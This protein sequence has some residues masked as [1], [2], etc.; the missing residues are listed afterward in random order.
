M[1]KYNQ[2]RDY[3][4]FTLRTTDEPKSISNL[5]CTNLDL[6]Y[7]YYLKDPFLCEHHHKSKAEIIS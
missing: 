1:F 3:V 7:Q 2:L 5:N 6:L 4:N